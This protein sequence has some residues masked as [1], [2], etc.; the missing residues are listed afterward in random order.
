[1]PGRQGRSPIAALSGSSAGSDVAHLR[2]HSRGRGAQRSLGGVLDVDDVDAA[3]DGQPR[4]GGV[5]HAHQ[6]PHVTSTRAPRLSK[7]TTSAR[8]PAPSSASS[9]R[10]SSCPSS[11]LADDPVDGGPPR[12]LAGAGRPEPQQR[13]HERPGL[14]VERPALDGR[15]RVAHQPLEPAQRRAELG[16]VAL[17]ERREQRGQ[18]ELGDLRRAIGIG[19]QVRER[20]LL[21]AARE[22]RLGRGDHEHAAPLVRHRVARQ[23]RCGARRPRGAGRP[24]RR[25][26]RGRTSTGRPPSGRRARPCAPSSPDR[27][28]ARP[29]RPA[30]PSRRAPA[31]CRSR[32]RHARGSPRARA[33]ALPAPGR[34]RR[35]S[36]A[37]RRARARRP[38]PRR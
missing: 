33:R 28:T 16:E 30:P 26:R 5:D 9:P 2:D 22:A 11:S 19:T 12:A 14:R 3:G 31:S 7:R 20:R 15:E 37:R 17:D 8:P 36:A 21:G 1:M 13:V 23:Q 4:L 27:A 6:Q 25:S 24:R 38:A 32:G 18:H 10:T 35:G 34:A 29:A